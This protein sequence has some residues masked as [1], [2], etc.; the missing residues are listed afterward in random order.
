M[1][2]PAPATR[3]TS[4]GRDDPDS[5]SRFTALR[6]FALEA[7]VGTA[8]RRTPRGRGST[9]PR[10]TRSRRSG[11]RPVA[12]NL[13][14]RSLRRARHA[15]GGDPVR[16]AGEPVHRVK[17]LR[18]RAGRGPGQRRPTARRV[19]TAA[20]SSTPRSCRC[21]SP[22]QPGTSPVT[23][24]NGWA[25]SREPTR[26]RPGLAACAAWGDSKVWRHG[27]THPCD[28][29]HARCRPRSASGQGDRRRTLSRH[30]NRVP[31]GPRPARRRGGADRPGRPAPRAR[32]AWS[33]TPRSPTATTPGSPRTRPAPGPSRS[34]PGPTRSAPG[35]TT[36]GIKIPAGVDVELMFTEARLLLERVKPISTSPT[37]AATSCSTARSTPP[38]TPAARP[39]RASPRS[40][41]PS[42]TGLLLAHP[43]R[44]L[45]TVEGPYPAYADR[46]ARAVQ[47]LVRVLPALGGRDARP[48]DRQGHQRQLPHRRQAARRGRG[49]GLRRHLPAAGPPDRRGQPQGPEQHADPGP[50]GHRLA[51]GDRLARTAATTRSTPTSAR[52]R[53][54]TRSS[55]APASSASRSRSTWPSRRRPTTPG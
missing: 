28:E 9:P 42:S 32:C 20:R 4:A 6:R 3:P 7:C 31:R 44:E 30:R 46:T 48:D 25:P 27:R 50:R 12:P 17:G 2:H 24:T 55:P 16:R 52:S 29:R 51:V 38:T 18:R 13:T 49:D 40:R 53:T 33:S 54:S 37:G 39:G 14:L 8:R 15:G 19:P 26:C 43:L 23:R 10:R 36:P 21:T 47:Q 34:R 41:T 35:S 22:A 5:G 1:L 45:V 11:P